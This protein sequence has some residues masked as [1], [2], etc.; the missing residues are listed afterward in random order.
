MR[1]STDKFY[2]LISLPSEKQV[3]EL[4]SCNESGPFAMYT[5]ARSVRT[6]IAKSL[7]RAIYAILHNT[8]VVLVKMELLTKYTKAISYGIIEKSTKGWPECSSKSTW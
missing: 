6:Y 7:K 2:P 3:S 8:K 1:K 5:R 4:I